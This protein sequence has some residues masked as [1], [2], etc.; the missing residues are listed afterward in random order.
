MPAQPD[1]PAGDRLRHFGL[2]VDY[3]NP[4]MWAQPWPDYYAEMNALCTYAEELGYD[5]LWLPEHHFAD[6]GYAPTPTLIASALSQRTSRIRLGLAVAV[7]PLYHPVRMAED[8][9]LVD[10]LSNGRFEPG[11]AVGWRPD[12]F[13]AFGLDVHERG[14]RTD[15]MLEVMNRL[16]SGETVTHKGRFFDLDGVRL[17]PPPVQQPRPT[18]WIGGHG[19]AAMRRAARFGDG[20]VGAY[21]KADEYALYLDELDACGR[22]RE[23]ARVASGLQFFM[24]SHDPERTFAMAAPYV[25]N[26]YGHYAAWNAGTV[27]ADTANELRAKG[28]LTVVTPEE[29]VTIIRDVVSVVPHDVFNIKMRPPGMPLDETVAHLELFAREVMPHFRD[30]VPA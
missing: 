24:V 16:W 9:A 22:G 27:R 30:E 8:C 20:I 26:W 2:S 14:A 28:Q 17:M 5:E 12:E 21:I 25:L 4:P 23:H 18:T 19:R 11:F 29:A 15:E 10:I 6:D 13:A 7:L 3:R 1:P